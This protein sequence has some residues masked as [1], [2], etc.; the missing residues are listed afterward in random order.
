MR[1][2][3]F[4]AIV[5]FISSEVLGSQVLS[6]LRYVCSYRLAAKS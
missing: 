1:I 3:Q 5:L 2:R 6:G 4:L